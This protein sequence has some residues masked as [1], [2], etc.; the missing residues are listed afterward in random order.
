MNKTRLRLFD[1]RI[2]GRLIRT[3]GSVTN[4]QI[5]SDRNLWI[6]IDRYFDNWKKHNAT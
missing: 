2:T 1:R 4:H 5:R 3:K 6:K